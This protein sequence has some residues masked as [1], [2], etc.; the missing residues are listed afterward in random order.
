MASKIHESA[1]SI[2]CVGFSSWVHTIK[3]AG[4]E[5]LWAFNVLHGNMQYYFVFLDHSF[6]NVLYCVANMNLH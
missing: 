5:W 2:E 4:D 6:L 1:G 3:T